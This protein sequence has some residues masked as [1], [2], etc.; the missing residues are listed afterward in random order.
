MYFL[1]LSATLSKQSNLAEEYKNQLIYQEALLSWKRGNQD[2]GRYFL[3]NLISRQSTDLRVKSQALRI[4]G[5][6]MAETKSENPNVRPSQ[7]IKQ[8]L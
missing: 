7:S 6:W 4:Y 8:R 5:N 2:I 1:F 3:K